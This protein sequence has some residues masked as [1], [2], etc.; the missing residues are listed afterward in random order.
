MEGVLFWVKKMYPSKPSEEMSLG[1]GAYSYEMC[2]GTFATWWGMLVCQ[3]EEMF[4]FPVLIRY[5]NMIICLV[6]FCYVSFC[7]FGGTLP[8]LVG[9]ISRDGAFGNISKITVRLIGVRVYIIW[10]F[11][12]L[13]SKIFLAMNPLYMGLPAGTP[14]I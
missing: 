11:F 4:P 2:L 14:K 13:L 5:N 10:V 9:S 8:N 6:L 3:M 1:F 12:F 7:N